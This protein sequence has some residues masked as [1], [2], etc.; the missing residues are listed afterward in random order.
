M[1]IKNIAFSKKV[2]PEVI[3]LLLERFVLVDRLLI[4]FVDR[5]GVT[6]RGAAAPDAFRLISERCVHFDDC[7]ISGMA[8][9]TLALTHGLMRSK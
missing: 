6:A 7:D 3:K 5:P 8:L 2:I 1:A 4:D 9:G